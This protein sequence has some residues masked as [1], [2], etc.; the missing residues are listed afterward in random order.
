MAGAPINRELL[1]LQSSQAGVCR[2]AYGSC[3]AM[4]RTSG[5]RGCGDPRGGRHGASCPATAPHRKQDWRDSHKTC[6]RRCPFLLKTCLVLPAQCLGRQG[7]QHHVDKP[8]GHVSY[9]LATSRD[10]RHRQAVK[11][12]SA[13]TPHPLATA[14]K[15]DLKYIYVAS[16]RTSL[17]IYVYHIHIDIQM[18]AHMKLNFERSHRPELPAP[19]TPPL[20]LS[21]VTS[22]SPCHGTAAALFEKEML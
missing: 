20:S 9:L 8:K 7:H 10:T 2:G 14:H 4:P 3:P 12:A 1:S 15:A 13:G 5:T 19:R 16:P 21:A 17:G 18:Q 6:V 11:S 22:K